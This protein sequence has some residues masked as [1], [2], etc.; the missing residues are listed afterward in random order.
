MHRG[1]IRYADREGPCA[2]DSGHTFDS[3]LLCELGRFAQVCRYTTR[4]LV[5]RS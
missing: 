2:R 3:I 1:R 4:S 5:L